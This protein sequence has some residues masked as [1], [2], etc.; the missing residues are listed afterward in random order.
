M[1]PAPQVATNCIM[2]IIIAWRPIEALA[3]LIKEELCALCGG[4]NDGLE[5]SWHSTGNGLDDDFEIMT[6]VT[7]PA[8]RYDY[9]HDMCV[10]ID[11]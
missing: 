6:E 10:S 2:I 11:E 7:N 8:Y 1:D 5:N 4:G 3:K 9:G